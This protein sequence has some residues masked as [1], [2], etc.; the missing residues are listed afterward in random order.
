MVFGE[1]GIV[2]GMLDPS[3]EPP[4]RSAATV[5]R[6]TGIVRKRV[7]RLSLWF[8]L[9]FLAIAVGGILFMVV[10]ELTVAPGREGALGE[11]IGVAVIILFFV[12]FL[13]AFAVRRIIG[14]DV[15]DAKEIARDGLAY[16]ARVTSHERL[17]FGGMHF[18]ELVWQE[19]G[20]NASAR[21]NIE[22]LDAD[23]AT[24]TELAVLARPGK[25]PVAV[26]LGDAMVVG[27]RRRS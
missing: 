6:W 17:A 1:R 24:G 15:R 10:G 14:R 12:A 16:S 13:P 2:A 26:V 22:K 23:P 21:F 3:D 5:E 11:D 20:R 25:R 7:E 18:I 19:D 27:Y 9:G 8:T 4:P